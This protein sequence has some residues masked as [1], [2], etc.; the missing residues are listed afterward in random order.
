MLVCD[1]CGNKEGV[2][3]IAL[4]ECGL[5]KET[6]AAIKVIV[7]KDLCPQCINYIH[8]KINTQKEEFHT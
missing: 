8:G 7:A 2:K 4:G 5:N 3:S 6:H 1:R